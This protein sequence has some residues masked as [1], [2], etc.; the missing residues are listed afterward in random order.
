MKGGVECKPTHHPQLSLQLTLSKTKVPF[1]SGRKWLTE[2]WRG[3][4]TA[5]FQALLFS[6]SL[7]KKKNLS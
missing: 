1:A 4:I 2:G 7:K 5:C 6:F 3:E